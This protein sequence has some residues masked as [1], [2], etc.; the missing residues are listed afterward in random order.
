MIDKAND[1]VKR[2]LSYIALSCSY[3]TDLK[4][5]FMKKSENKENLFKKKCKCT[6]LIT[7]LK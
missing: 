3:N 6:V 1:L 4:S 7:E 2:S 5:N